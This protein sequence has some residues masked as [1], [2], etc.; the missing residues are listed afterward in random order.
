MTSTSLPSTVPLHVF[1]A[2][3]RTFPEDMP[4]EACLVSELDT[5]ELGFSGQDAS[6]CS[7]EEHQKHERLHWRTVG[8]V[9]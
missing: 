9:V 5:G 8:L 2:D 3:V 6:K 1:T 7:D 4:M